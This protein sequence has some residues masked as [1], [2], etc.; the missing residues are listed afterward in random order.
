VA[1]GA[2]CLY[3]VSDWAKFANNIGFGELARRAVDYC[4]I[5]CFDKDSF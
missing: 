3:G 4:R 1:A 5:V 2:S